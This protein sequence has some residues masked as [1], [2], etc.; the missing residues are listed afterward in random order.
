MSEGIRVLLLGGTGL[1]G[2]HCLRLLA[3]D[4]R[5][6]RV[7]AM[8][9]KPSEFTGLSSKV[10]TVVG[11]FSQLPQR[12]PWLE[13]DAVI[14]C[15]GTTIRKAGS[16]EAFR[17]VDF[18]YPVAVGKLALA[19]GASHYLLVSAMGADAASRIFYNRVK[20]E[21]EGAILALGYSHVTIARPSLL[22]G[23]RQEFRLGEELAKPFGWLL[24]SKVKPVH[25]SQVAAGLVN[26]ACSPL[27][28]VAYLDNTQLRSNPI[29]E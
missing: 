16:Q 19:N 10:V 25:A 26:S 15:L 13:V 28:A 3:A 4:E 2:G 17:K 21:V 8:V 9:R 11:D 5:C 20:G 29:A 18:D 6:S 22:L 24:P 1:V 27:A 14:C 12:A 23:Q 7:Y